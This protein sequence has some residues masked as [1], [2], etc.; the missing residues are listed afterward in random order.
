MILINDVMINVCEPST[1]DL[2]VDEPEKY[3]GG[4]AGLQVIGRR[5]EEEKVLD[6]LEIIAQ[7]LGK[8]E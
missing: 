3:E 5:Y 4:P 6:I 8:I 2:T 1:D 7:S